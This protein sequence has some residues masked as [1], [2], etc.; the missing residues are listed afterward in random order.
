[1]KAIVIC[2]ISLAA[3]FSPDNT[4]DEPDQP[5]PQPVLMDPIG[6]WNLTLQW[7]ND[8]QCATA[9]TTMTRLLHVSAHQEGFV[10]VTDFEEEDV[11]T[12]SLERDESMTTLTASISLTKLQPDGSQSVELTS[13]D[14]TA[15][16]TT[17]TITG[18]GNNAFSSPDFS[19][20]QTLDVS[21][22]LN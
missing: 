17:G 21:G 14:V 2:M 9:D 19:C 6:D 16:A 22:Q 10:V 11:T 8:G 3:C 12:F 20:T 5:P 18:T 13:V 7:N 4:P 1:M 15:I